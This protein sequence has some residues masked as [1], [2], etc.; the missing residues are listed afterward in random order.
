MNEKLKKIISTYLDNP[1]EID[2]LKEDP[3]TLKQII[4]DLFDIFTS[5]K[6]LFFSQILDILPFFISQLGIPFILMLNESEKSLITSLLEF[7]SNTNKTLS[8][9]EKKNLFDV[10]KYFS[11]RFSHISQEVNEIH[12][13][14][15]FNDLVLF[16]ETNFPENMALKERPKL[17][18]YEQLYLSIFEKNFKAHMC[19]KTIK[20]FNKNKDFKPLCEHLKIL[21][22]F[23][24]SEFFSAEFSPLERNSLL[25]QAKKTEMLKEEIKSL[26]PSFENFLYE[27]YTEDKSLHN[28]EYY[29][30]ESEY[31]MKND[32][33]SHFLDSENFFFDPFPNNTQQMICGFLNAKGGR[34][35]IGLRNNRIEGITLSK[36]NQDIVRLQIDENV[37][38]FSPLVQAEE[39]R[40]YF[41][42]V[43][44]KKREFIDRVVIK[45]V[46]NPN[47]KEVYFTPK[48]DNLVFLREE[49]GKEKCF[50]GGDLWQ[51]L[52]L[53][54]SDSKNINDKVLIADPLPLEINEANLSKMKF[55]NQYFVPKIDNEQY[56]SE[57]HIYGNNNNNSA[58]KKNT[59]NS[60]KT[61]VQN[62]TLESTSYFMTQNKNLEKDIKKMLEVGKSSEKKTK[63][64]KS[65]DYDN[66]L[67]NTLFFKYDSKTSEKAFLDSTRAISEY[68]HDIC[69]KQSN[70]LIRRRDKKYFFIEMVKEIEDEEFNLMKEI[71]AQGELEGLIVNYASK[72]TSEK[73][74]EYIIS[75]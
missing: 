43:L 48:P 4:D 54:K 25:L 67:Y 23:D 29:I 17:S 74:H 31:A 60:A 49:N 62:K 10:W 66:F 16:L 13:I 52:Y 59:F 36:K 70:L 2:E 53:E 34:I 19:F 5:K 45:I 42:P 64:K 69:G 72:R 61:T 57:S 68:L 55:N 73:Y 47:P 27:N 21:S 40:T 7:I 26:D 22:S 35:Y 58:K 1:H 41:Y 9:N 32:L 75:K 12:E 18:K 65:K 71:Y 33:Q 14:S 37:R 50:L 51:K 44:G 39:F 6:S 30:K 46:I 3:D 56:I 38:G 63:K 11:Q 20:I 8:P 28:Q 24:Q 15:K